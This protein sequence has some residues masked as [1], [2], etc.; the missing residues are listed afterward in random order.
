M[1]NLAIMNNFALAKMFTIINFSCRSKLKNENFIYRHKLHQF[2][3]QQRQQNCERKSLKFIYSEKAT[4]FCEI[5]NLLLSYVVPVRSKVKILQN[6]VAFSKYINFTA[7]NKWE[8]QFLLVR[9]SVVPGVSKNLLSRISIVNQFHK[10][11]SI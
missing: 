3:S 9:R 5:F 2:I 1:N 6:S 8:Q 4:K 11:V 10:N 7:K